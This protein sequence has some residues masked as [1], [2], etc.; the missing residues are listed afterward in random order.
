MEYS[1]AH[2]KERVA[3]G[4]P[5][6]SFQAVS[7]RAVNGASDM[8]A[9]HH[10]LHEAVHAYLSGRPNWQL[11]AALVVEFAGPAAISAQFG[12]QHTLAAMGYFEEHDAPWLFRRVNADISR[13]DGLPLAARDVADVGNH[14]EERRPALNSGMR[15]GSGMI[16][17]MSWPRSCSTSPSS[18]ST[19]AST[20]G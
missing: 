13:I 5:I 11:A 3:F 20:P 4:K 16:S 14:S 12:A 18:T 7:H 19:I 17:R 9:C 1:I 6:G 15:R 10:L 2:A 8:T